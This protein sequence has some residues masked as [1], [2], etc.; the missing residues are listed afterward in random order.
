MGRPSTLSPAWQNLAKACGGYKSLRTE[1]GW[2]TTVFQ[3]RANGRVRIPHADH[4]LVNQL[5]KRLG[6]SSPLES[7]E[8]TPPPSNLDPLRLAG[9]TLARG[10]PLGS[11]TTAVL[12]QT[13]TTEQ[14]ISV[15][16]TGTDPDVLRAA[17]Y[18]LSV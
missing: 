2:G 1:L 6:V 5:A 7:I 16:E 15:A 8:T 4:V 17:T 12:R 3:R 14:L 9:Q 11:N 10:F 13:Y 18:L